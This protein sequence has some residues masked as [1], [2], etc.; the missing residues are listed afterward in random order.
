MRKLINLSEEDILKKR[1]WIAV[2]LCIAMSMLALTACGDTETKDTDTNTG[3]VAASSET[4]TEDSASSQMGGM[5]STVKEFSQDELLS[6]KHH[7]EMDIEGQ[8]TVSLELD[9]DQAP[10][11]VTNFIDLAKQGFY[12]G[13]TFH[14]IIGGQFAQGGDPNGNGTGDPGYSIKGEFTANGV[15]NT[16]SHTRGAISMARTSDYNGGGC[17]FFIMDSDY[18]GFDG[19]YACFGYVT[20][21][22]EVIDA[23]CS[24]P[25]VVDGNGTVRPGSQPVISAVR[26]ID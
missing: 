8:G 17:Q 4:E 25:E 20:E 12:D 14:R 22:M 1:T 19:Q 15:N 13:L 16:L 10:V 26:V 7:V 11:S 18:Q 23:I 5:N 24:N 3:K 6:G 21:G 9:A 2:L